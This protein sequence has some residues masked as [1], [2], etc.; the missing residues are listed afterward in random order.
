MRL[1][2]LDFNEQQYGVSPYAINSLIQLQNSPFSKSPEE[3][4]IREQIE[5]DMLLI[6]VS[7]L[8]KVVS[9]AEGISEEIE[10]GNGVKLDGFFKNLCLYLK[11][12]GRGDDAEK[13]SSSFGLLKVDI[14]EGRSLDHLQN[15]CQ[16]IVNHLGKI[17]AKKER[18]RSI[19]PLQTVRL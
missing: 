16:P 7:R 13:L 18:S 19:D 10:Y 1:V 6:I 12:T 8:R 2:T 11:Q 15:V 9:S 5:G 17:L 3:A 4:D 14:N